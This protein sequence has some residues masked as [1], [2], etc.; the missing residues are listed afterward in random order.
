MIAVVKYLQSIR[1]SQPEVLPQSVKDSG[2]CVRSDPSFLYKI[3]KI[4]LDNS[5][6]ID[7]AVQCLFRYSQVMSYY[8]NF[9]DWSSL[10]QSRAKLLLGLILKT[11]ANNIED[12]PVIEQIV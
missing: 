12:K 5:I 2:F 6:F 10:K 4:C 9:N 8:R 11:L 3:A 1:P 7:L